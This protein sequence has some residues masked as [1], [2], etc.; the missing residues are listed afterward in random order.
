M[1]FGEKR[2]GQLFEY[3]HRLPMSELCKQLLRATFEHGEGLPQ[4]D[5]ITIVLVRRLPE[6]VS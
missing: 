4:A 3:H 2:V 1:Q 6:V 5:D